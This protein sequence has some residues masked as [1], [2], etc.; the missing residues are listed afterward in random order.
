[1]ER[2][3]RGSRGYGVPEG[4]EDNGGCRC[5]TQ[6]SREARWEEI[7]KAIVWRERTG[8]DPREKQLRTIHQSLLTCT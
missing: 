5:E 2:S 1:M 7:Q 4:E 8:A 6:W 3:S